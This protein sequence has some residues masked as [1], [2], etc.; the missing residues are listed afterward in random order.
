MVWPL[1]R[2]I[3]I[4]IVMKTKNVM[5]QR[6]ETAKMK[7]QPYGRRIYKV[8]FCETACLANPDLSINHKLN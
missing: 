1:H 3:C 2:G 7:F 8:I 5:P 4:L 6:N